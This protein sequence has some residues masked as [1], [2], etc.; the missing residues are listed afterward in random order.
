MIGVLGRD[1]FGLRLD[2][3]VRSEQVNRRSLVVI[4]YKRVE[5]VKGCQMLFIG[6]SETR[7]L[8]SILTKLAGRSILTV[9]DI[10]SFAGAGGMVRF[11]TVKHSVQLEINLEALNAAKLTMSSKL[12]RAAQIL[13]GGRK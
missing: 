9:S 8:P 2:E 6:D 12:L 4:R 13:P 10:D 3:A 11:V 5:D 7:R 1:P